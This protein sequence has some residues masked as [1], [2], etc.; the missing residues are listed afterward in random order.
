MSNTTQK[1]QFGF[2]NSTGRYLTAESF[3]CRV[4][5]TATAMK[6]KQIWSVE[7]DSSRPGIVF[8]R[9]NTRLYLA[10]D[11]RGALTCDTED[12]RR[13]PEA[14]F[15]IEYAADGRW[16]FRS[17]DTGYYVGGKDDNVRCYEKT[18]GN[19]ELWTPHLAMHPQVRDRQ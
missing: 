16:A 1:W 19:T 6:R 2:S 11:E 4:N 13:T 10:G 12:S 3:G 17:D 7:Q 15:I 9:A 8:L 5:A 18:A 14:A